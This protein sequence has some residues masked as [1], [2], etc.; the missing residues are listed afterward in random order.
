MGYSSTNHFR[1]WIFPWDTAL[2]RSCS[3]YRIWKQ[4]I[5]STGKLSQDTGGSTTNHFWS[6]RCD[7]LLI[8]TRLY[9]NFVSQA[10]NRLKTAVN[11][12]V[13]LPKSLWYPVSYSGWSCPPPFSPKK[14][15]QA[16]QGF[17]LDHCI[18]PAIHIPDKRDLFRFW[19]KSQS[20]VN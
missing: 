17:W 6:V 18:W 13:D 10:V 11:G 16:F 19:S 4:E 5:Q 14:G 9:S 3:T 12:W 8:Y 20:G 7:L 15:T 1:R 2:S